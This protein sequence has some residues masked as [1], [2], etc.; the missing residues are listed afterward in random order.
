MIYLLI[1]ILLLFPATAHAEWT[2]LDTVLQVTGL[3]L[4]DLDRRQT[5][6][7]GKDG[8]ETNPYLGGHPS[9]GQVN[10]YFLATATIFTAGSL[11]LTN[12]K[13]PW[14]TLWHGIWI[15]TEANATYHNYLLGVRC[16]W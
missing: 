11:V 9:H 8:A 1:I 7:I 12:E 14:R 15:G 16:Q 5:I 6:A 13:F 3:F 4:I 2:T 10:R